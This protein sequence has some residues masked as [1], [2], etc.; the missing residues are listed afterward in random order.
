MIGDGM[1]LS[2]ITAAMHQKEGSLHLEEFKYLGF[3]KV[4]GLD[5]LIPKCAATATA[6]GCG[7]KTHGR[8]VG[9][10]KNGKPVQSILEAAADAGLA[11]GIVVTAPITHST[12]AGFY[13]H[14]QDKDM[15]EEIAEDLLHSDLDFFVGGGAKHF[16]RR[17]DGRNLLTELERKGY[18]LS[19]SSRSDFHNLSIDFNKKFG[20]FTADDEPL[21]FS[22]GRDY[23][24]QASATAM[25]YLSS[26][27]EKGFF[28]MIEASQID[29]AGH[30]NDA[31]Y[32]LS[33]LLDFDN[34]LGEVLKFAKEDGQT[35]VIFTADH[36]TG[37]FAINLGSTADKLL[38]K[39][40]TDKHTASLVPV[41][42]YGPGQE[43]FSGIFDN[44]AIFF[45]MK[46]A[47]GLYKS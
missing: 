38:I 26:R 8:A 2:Q 45:K 27:S 34:A 14:R 17:K 9:V 3:Q 16:Y 35:L 39:F 40:T 11:T 31:D 19:D 21:P 24:A 13:A 15:V 46:R 47:L 4:N 20:Y 30:A 23:L 25:T 1:G 28:L 37:G 22:R 12:P 43:L 6:I 10:D 44:T 41:F 29:W 36:E 32:V 7:V 42:A 33:E 5:N 18:A